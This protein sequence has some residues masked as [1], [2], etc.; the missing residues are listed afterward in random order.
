[1]KNNAIKAGTIYIIA[2]F[3]VKGISFLLLPIFTKI[4]TT[5]DYGIVSTYLSCV[6]ITS[7]LVGLA[8]M[9]SIRAAYTDFK[10]DIYTYMSTILWISIIACF[11]VTLIFEVLFRQRVSIS[12]IL[13][14]CCMIQSLGVF[15]CNCLTNLYMMQERIYQRAILM[16]IPNLIIPVLGICFIKTSYLPGYIARILPMV[17]VNLIVVIYCILYIYKYSRMRFKI[18]Y[19]RYAFHICIPLFFQAIA[20]DVLSTFDCIMITYFKSASQTAVY[21]VAYSISMILLSVTGAI[22]SVWIPWFTQKMKNE[23]NEMITDY[24]PKYIDVALAATIGI[25]SVAPEF[26]RWFL[27]E[28]YAGGV[29]YIVPITLAA[30][31]IFLYSIANDIEYYYKKFKSMAFNTMISATVNIVLNYIF[32]PK[33]G[34]IA[35]A[36]TTLISYIISMIIHFYFAKKVCPQLIKANHYVFASVTL[37]LCIFIYYLA[38]D[39]MVI[40]WMYCIVIIVI[41]GLKNKNII[42]NAI[43]NKKQ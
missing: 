38:L 6:N 41:I 5:H 12:G 39:C 15:M 24:I 1:M 16:I 11:I 42:L 7:I 32:I 25:L 9:A 40:R 8:M 21:N 3:F 31:V 22:N 2:N 26:I 28:S 10:E 37:I 43:I 34:A 13:V 17:I 36:Y 33:Y 30:F 14:I 18:Q 4:M 19:A 20:A 29:Y 27:A 35:A 23:E